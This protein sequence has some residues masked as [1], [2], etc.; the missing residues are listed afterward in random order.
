MYNIL[1]NGSNACLIP[2]L[3]EGGRKRFQQFVSLIL[4]ELPHGI[5]SLSVSR[6]GTSFKSGRT[7]VGLSP[8]EE[9]VKSVC[10]ESKFGPVSDV[11]IVC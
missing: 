1:T 9:V 8:K 3:R 5:G 4:I 10:W 6:L 2:G 11:S 7:W